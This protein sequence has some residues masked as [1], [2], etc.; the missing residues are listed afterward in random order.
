MAHN[1]YDA[2]CLFC[3]APIEAG[4]A[5][6]VC[7]GTT[8]DALLATFGG[9]VNRSPVD[10]AN[11]NL[12]NRTHRVPQ[13]SMLCCYYFGR[14]PDCTCVAYPI[15]DTMPCEGS[16]EIQLA[17]TGAPGADVIVRVVV[18]ED[19]D[20]AAEFER[21]FVGVGTID[22]WNIGDIPLDVNTLRRC[23]WSAATCNLGT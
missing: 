4:C 5:C 8:P 17:G 2:S 19:C 16:V 21:T 13:D 14:A 12:W 10:C 3:C 20:I 1:V 15:V 23:N 6:H 18:L 11:C 9:V 7:S 22:C